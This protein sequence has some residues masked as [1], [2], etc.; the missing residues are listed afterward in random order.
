LPEPAPAFVDIWVLKVNNL[1]EKD[2]VLQDSEV[3]EVKWYDLATVRNWK[4]GTIDI[5]SNSFE[6][7]LAPLLKWFDQN[8]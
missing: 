5:N 1:S 6:R 2:F 4:N 7:R 3:A 8:S